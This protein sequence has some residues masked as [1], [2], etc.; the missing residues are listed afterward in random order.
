MEDFLLSNGYQLGKTIGE[1]TYSK[2][3]E[4][5][6]KKHQRKVA[7]KIIDKMGGPEG[8]LGPLWRKGGLAEVGGCFLQSEGAIPSSPLVLKKARE[9]VALESVSGEQRKSRKITP[10]QTPK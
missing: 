10:S 9:A 5:V 4:A 8:E 2:V 3:K 1:G 7:I 6:S